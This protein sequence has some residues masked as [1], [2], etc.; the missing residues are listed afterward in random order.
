MTIDYAPTMIRPTAVHETLRRHQLVDGYDL[1]LDLERSHGSWLHDSVT[2][3]DFLDFFTCFA[4]WP[5]GYD[6]PATSDPDF[7]DELE[8]VARNKPSNSDL[9]TT[10]MAAFVERF[11]GSVTPPGFP[12]HFWISG[13][14]LAVENGLKTAFD[15]KARK[16][17]PETTD[18]G[19]KLVVLHFRQAFHGRSGYTL[20]L[21]NTVPDK[22]ALFPKFRWPRVHNPAVEFDLDGGI[23]NDIESEERRACDEIEAAFREHAGLVAAIIIEPMQGEGGDNHFRPEFLAKLR[24]YADEHETLLIYDEIQTGFYGS[25][26]AWMW[27]HHD[28]PPDIAC[29]GKKTQVC[30]I[31]ASRR[32]DEVEGHV[33]QTSSRINSTWGG[34]LVDMV[35]CRKFIEIIQEEDLAENVFERGAQLV[36]GLRELARE[37]S[38]LSNVRGIGSMVAF[39]L[40]TSEARDELLKALAAKRLLALASGP[41][42]IRFRLPLVVTEEEIQTGLTRI[43]DCLPRP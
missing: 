16:V 17:G 9:Y 4:S 10:H 21:T 40:E 18:D 42:S 1:V 22:I 32:L 37:G 19:N 2:G 13:G 35:R 27:Q 3:E 28:V 15:W 36:L 30:G 29:F 38:P 25:G 26:K 7:R 39:T 20:S 14:A 34:N 23:A 6:H 11:A 33:F 41:R 24:A 12:Y 5:L 43:A 8:L 31:Y